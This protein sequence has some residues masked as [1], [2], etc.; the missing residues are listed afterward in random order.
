MDVLVTDVHGAGLRPPGLISVAPSGMPVGA[1][2]VAEVSA[3]SGDV[4]PR[5]DGVGA[6]C[7][8][9]APQLKNIKVTVKNIL[10][11]WFDILRESAHLRHANV[12]ENPVRSH[13]DTYSVPGEPTIGR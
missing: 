3:L 2:D 4:A 11:L 1:P 9:P 12:A 5:P 7:A 10:R 13:T 8:R 6:V